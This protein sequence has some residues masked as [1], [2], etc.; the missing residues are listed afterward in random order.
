MDERPG[1]APECI[2]EREARKELAELIGKAAREFEGA[3]QQFKEF[4]GEVPDRTSTDPDR[5][6]GSGL[7]KLFIE[8]SMQIEDLKTETNKKFIEVNK[9]LED[10]KNQLPAA[11]AQRMKNR[12]TGWGSIAAATIAIATLFVGCYRVSSS[13]EKIAFAMSH[14]AP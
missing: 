4:V 13:V 12:I 2:A 7:R 6:S 11:Q 8:Q 1:R 5:R 9:G 10:I 14:K 3:T